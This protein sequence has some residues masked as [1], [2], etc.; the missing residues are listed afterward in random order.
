VVKRTHLLSS[1][2][3]G[4]EDLHQYGRRYFLFPRFY[5]AMSGDNVK[6]GMYQE[7]SSIIFAFNHGFY[8]LYESGDILLDAR[9]FPPFTTIS[10][11]YPVGSGLSRKGTFDVRSVSHMELGPS[12]V[13]IESCICGRTDGLQPENCLS[14]AYIHAGVNAFIAASRVTA[15]P[16]YL[17]PGKIVEGFGIWGFINATLNLKLRGLYPQPHFGAVIAEDFIL[18]MVMA[19]N[20]TGLALRNAKNLYLD[21]D[22]N[23]TFLW[24]PPLISTGCTLI[25]NMLYETLDPPYSYGQYLDKKYHCLHEFNLYGDPAF[26]PYQ[27]I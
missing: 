20:T 4:F 13:Y 17:E 2:K 25:D 19:D 10:R 9:G 3:E 5:E 24:T 1:Q 11:F 22:A 18:D 26:N 21:K 27:P 14:Q 23:T 15:D 6:G 7:Q 12:V 16:G 8:Y